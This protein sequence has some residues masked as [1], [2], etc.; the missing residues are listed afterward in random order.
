[1]ALVSSCGWRFDHQSRSSSRSMQLAMVP[2][3]RTAPP[4]TRSGEFS[5]RRG[6]PAWRSAPL[7]RTTGWTR[8]RCSVAGEDTLPLLHA[9]KASSRARQAQ[10]PSA[11]GLDNLPVIRFL[12]GQKPNKVSNPL[13][14]F[15]L[16]CLP[17]PFAFTFTYSNQTAPINT[18]SIKT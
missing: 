10:W 3:C 13:I 18:H 6:P 14:Y 5:S 15:H 9:V 1:M 2:A 7:L 16:R 8:G 17:L 12:Q 11:L 4:M